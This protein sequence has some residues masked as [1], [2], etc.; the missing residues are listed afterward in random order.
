[1]TE[2]S[3]PSKVFFLKHLRKQENWIKREHLKKDQTPLF[4]FWTKSDLGQDFFKFY[5]KNNSILKSSGEC[6]KIFKKQNDLF[7]LVHL[8]KKLTLIQA[9][10]QGYRP[11][12]E[13]GDGKV[14]HELILTAQKKISCYLEKKDSEKILKKIKKGLAILEKNAPE[15]FTRFCKYTH[16][17]IGVREKGIVSYSLQSLPGF[18]CINFY[19]RDFIDLLD[20][21]IHENG[22]H[23]LNTYLNKET[24]IHEDDEKIY[25][26][27]WRKSMRPIRGIYHAYFTFYW[28]LDLFRTLSSCKEDFILSQKRKIKERAMEEYKML[29]SCWED[30]CHAYKY[31]KITKEG[32]LVIKGINRNIK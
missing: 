25:Y 15:A 6:F 7:E 13:V 19:D 21:L 24:L 27:P 10:K 22:H 12:I 32:W 3:H 9:K 17:L 31:K 26:S 4:D 1:M 5:Q 16:A 23:H 14:E 2:K 29:S 11:V 20:D 18:S 28:A 30:L 8:K